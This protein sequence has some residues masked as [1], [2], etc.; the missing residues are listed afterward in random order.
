MTRYGMVMDVTRC[1][2]C[3]NCFLA[4]K[5]EHCG[6]DFAPYSLSQPM[7]GHYW[8]RL[9]EKERGKYLQPELYGQPKERGI[10]F[11]KMEEPKVNQQQIIEN[12]NTNWIEKQKEFKNENK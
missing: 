6:N 4:C 10:N 3:Y 11:E 8:M 12:P 1:N 7:T 2:G 9:I 5:D